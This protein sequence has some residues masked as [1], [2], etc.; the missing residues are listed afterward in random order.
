MVAN[1]HPAWV[2]DFMKWAVMLVAVPVLFW[3]ANTAMLGLSRH[4]YVLATNRQIPS[5]AGKL[6]RNYSTPY[7]AIIIAALLALALA[8]PGDIRFLARVYAFGALLAVTIAQISIVRL[9][10]VEPDLERPY[11]V[12]WNVRIGSH[13]LPLPAMLGALISGLAWISVF[14]LHHTAVYVGGGWMLFGLVF[15]VI[16]RLYVEGTPLTRRVQVPEASLKKQ[17][18]GGGVL[19]HPG[20][21]LRHPARRRHRQHSGSAGRRGGGEGR[22][23]SPAG[24]RLRGGA[25]AHGPARCAPAEGG[26][27]AGGQGARSRSRGRG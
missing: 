15:Y 7:I 19:D 26:A 21:G 27:G 6:E 23:A 16:Y 25:A 17:P 13:D 14:L 4:V 18:D 11:K 22:A 3:A 9:R 12:P 24:G 10:V 20:A 8:I 1:Y 2:A 5:W